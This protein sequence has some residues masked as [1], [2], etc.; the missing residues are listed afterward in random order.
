MHITISGNIGSGKTTLAKMLAD[1]YQWDIYLED[2][3]K[4]P[5]LKDFYNDMQK[6]AFNLQIYFLHKRFNQL[7]EIK[8]KQKNVVQDRS[9]YEDVFVFATNLNNLG[10]LSQRDFTTY[11]TL[12]DLMQSLIKGPDLLI[13]LRSSVP[14]LLKQ[15]NS[16]GREYE[17][18]INANY[19]EQLN[20]QYE[21]WIE[22]Y[23][24]NKLIIIDVDKLNFVNNPKNF[25]YILEKL[26]KQIS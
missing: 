23:D 21:N 15:I 11:K 20:I 4:N 2:V 18:N 12:F 9:I 16:R 19:L 25:N 3:I 22:K 6:W 24:K 7:L 10:L 8:N 26:K 17:K 14:N 13:Y 1:F 5:Y